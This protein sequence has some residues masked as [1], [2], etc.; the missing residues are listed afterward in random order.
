MKFNAF[1]LRMAPI[2][3]AML[4]SGCAA[5]NPTPPEEVIA[6]RAV[7]RLELLRL[8]EAKA[9]YQYTT[10]GYRQTSTVGR[11]R[12]KYGGAA[13]WRR[14]VVDDVTCNERPS[15]RC[16]VA[17]RIYYLNP[18]VGFESDRVFKEVWIKSGGEWYKVEE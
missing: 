1:Q 8:G 2:A 10:P 11:Y 4:L 13:A 15:T 3:L 18:V 7:E 5:L 17:L 12:V 6:Q 14:F 16:E 9:S